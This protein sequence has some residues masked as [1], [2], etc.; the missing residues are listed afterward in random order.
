MKLSKET[1][2]LARAP[3]F[4]GVDPA[5]LRLLALVAGKRTFHDGEELMVQGEE[6]QAAFVIT[7]GNAEV[8]IRAGDQETSVAILGSNDIVGEMALLTESPRTATV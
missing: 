6:G 1:E 8:L 3:L 4:R 2:I 5:Q 7:S